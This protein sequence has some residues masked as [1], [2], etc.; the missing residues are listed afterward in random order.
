[1]ADRDFFFLWF[2]KILSSKFLK[3]VFSEKEMLQLDMP[4][5][6]FAGRSNV[7]KSTL[8]NNLCKS[9]SLAKTSSIPG[10]T[11]S[12]NYF[13][14]NEKIL[15]VDLPG[16]GYAKAPMIEREK[17]KKLIENYFNSTKNL[18]LI[19]VL[20]DIRHGLLEIDNMMIDWVN[21]F[22]FPFSIILTKSDKLSRNETSNTVRNIRQELV[23]YPNLKEVIPV[24]CITGFGLSDILKS[25]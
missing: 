5:F 7:G 9:K 20:V 6:V 2:M 13:L 22:D 8:I 16:Y 21:H 25:I 23:N 3:S 4:E 24:S 14:I 1:V 19:F 18:N 17:W 15:F 11:Q 10:K 12:V